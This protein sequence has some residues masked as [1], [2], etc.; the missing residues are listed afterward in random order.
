MSRGVLGVNEM[1]ITAIRIQS[2]PASTERNLK[3]KRLESNRMTGRAGKDLWEVSWRDGTISW[4]L[5]ITIRS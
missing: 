1:L 2:H 3:V 5:N 4:R